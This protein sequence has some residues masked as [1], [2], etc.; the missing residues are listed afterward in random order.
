MIKKTEVVNNGNYIYEEFLPT[1][2][3]DIKVYTVGPDYAHAESRR[4][5]VIDGNVRR[6]AQGREIRYP[7][8][9]TFDEKAIA[10][11]IVKLF[12]QNV[13]G[14]DLLRSNGKSYVCDVNGWS[15][16]KGN[17]KFN[18]DLAVI[19]KDMIF[20]RFNFITT[21]KITNKVNQ[22]LVE[23]SMRGLTKNQYRPPIDY[24]KE[25]KEELRSIVAIFRHGDRTPKQKMKMKVKSSLFI[26]FFIEACQI[27]SKPIQKEIKIK[28][29][30]LMHKFLETSMEVYK[31]VIQNSKFKKQSEYQIN[32]PQKKENDNIPINNISDPLEEQIEYKLEQLITVLQLHGNFEGFNRKIQIKPIE[33]QKIQDQDGQIKFSKPTKLLIILKC[34]NLQS[35]CRGGELTH[36]G[37][38][39][40]KQY[41]KKFRIN[42][43]PSEKEGL[44]RLH[45]TYRHDLKT[46][47]S[48]EG[49][50]Q[51]TA[52]FFLQGLLDQDGDVTSTMATLLTRNQTAQEL[53]DI[54]EDPEQN[55]QNQISELLN[56]TQDLTTKFQEMYKGEKLSNQMLQIM[57]EI[58]NPKEKLDHQYE[59]VRQLEQKLFYKSQQGKKSYYLTL[60]DLSQVNEQCHGESVSLMFK[61]W[62]KLKVDYKS[63][64]HYNISKIPD[65]YDNIKYDIIHNN[66]FLLSIFPGAKELYNISELLASFVV[67]NEF[68]ITD[69]QKFARAQTVVGPL[70]EKIKK[71]IKWWKEREDS[72]DF[73]KWK[74]EEKLGILSPWRHVR[75]RFYFANASHLY[76]L[77]NLLHIGLF[78]QSGLITNQKSEELEN[79]KFLQYLTHIVFRLYEDL[80]LDIE[81]E[82]R[83]RLEI[84][85]SQGNALHELKEIEQNHYVPIKELIPINLNLN[86]S[87]VIQFFNSLSYAKKKIQDEL[88]KEE[89]F[90][91]TNSL[92]ASA[93]LEDKKDK[94]ENNK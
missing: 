21:Y 22:S 49:R 91:T 35:K 65:I 53:L 77:F 34:K 29:P 3:F 68:G 71:D 16:V 20:K 46:F 94:L 84:S 45:N 18:K 38:F 89:K 31:E 80:N 24:T 17:E 26:D 6:N 23:S 14:F 2:G 69:M 12:G 28:N 47:T 11:N 56:S 4:A 64:S 74:K 79:L 67:P 19:V 93:N 70:C 86:L 76:S 78:K 81:T 57:R 63:N 82:N 54:D 33:V 50:C 90:K 44:L 10:K 27:M 55:Y 25:H 92:A 30:K 15:F 83:F 37:E 36:A 7:V 41:G 51:K 75:T 59:L 73:F 88:F 8:Q 1:D 42:Q 39:Q 61:R 43:Y 40:A 32:S 52:G 9:L 85:I 60:Q 48:D 62:R 5:P 58:G 66:S 13:C 72:E 87:E